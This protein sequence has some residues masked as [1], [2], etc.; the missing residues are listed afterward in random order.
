MTMLISLLNITNGKAK[1]LGKNLESEILKIRKIM[2]DCF[3][4]DILFDDLK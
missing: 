1:I 4:F 2:G 3:Q